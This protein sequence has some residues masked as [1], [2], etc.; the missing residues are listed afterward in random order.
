VNVTDFLLKISYIL[1]VLCDP[2]AQSVEHLTFN[3]GVARSNRA[4]VTIFLFKEISVK[5]YFL[6]PTNILELFILV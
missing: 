6:S 1:F 4:W 5:E 2:L 3:Q